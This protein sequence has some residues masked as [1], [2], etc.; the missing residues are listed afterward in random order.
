MRG[1]GLYKFI[2]IIKEKEERRRN[3]SE[4]KEE[5]RFTWSRQR[6][7]SEPLGAAATWIYR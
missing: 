5:E 3:E 4:S 2:K 7:V 6:V 1:Y